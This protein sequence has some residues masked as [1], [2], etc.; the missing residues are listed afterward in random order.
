MVEGNTMQYRNLGGS[1]LKVSVLSYG[2]WLTGHNAEAEAANF[3]CI[4]KSI[5]S[6]VNFIDT[7]EI[8]GMGTAETI[9]GNALKKGE[10]EREEL[11]VSTKFFK[12]GDGVNR[13]GLSR[14]HL[15]EGMRNSLKRLQLDYVDIMFLHRPSLDTPLEESIRA[16]NHLID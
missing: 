11:V 13:T 5:E 16:V 4:K 8:Y 2:N 6:G 15:I 1:G 10:W 14:K 9:V 12:C 7:A 3:D